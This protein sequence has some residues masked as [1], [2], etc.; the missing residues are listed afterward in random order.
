MAST[1]QLFQLD[2]IISMLINGGGAQSLRSVV[3]YDN[4]VCVLYLQRMI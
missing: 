1:C 2:S 4:A 3:S